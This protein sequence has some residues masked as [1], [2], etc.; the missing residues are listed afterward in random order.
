MA[1]II[2]TTFLSIHF[3]F[4][5]TL[6]ENKNFESLANRMAN[7][8][9]A[10]IVKAETVKKEILKTMSKEKVLIFDARESREFEVSHLPGAKHVGYN[11][12]NAKKATEGIHKDQKIIVYCTVGYRSGQVAQKLRKLGYN[13]HNLLGGITS[14]VNE[15]GPLVNFRNT[16]TQKVHT[17]SKKRAKWFERGELIH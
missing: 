7:K 3:L 9:S 13:A 14:W 1:N 16:P 2:L 4:A 10:P 8:S 17:Y 11:K 15:D 12:F 6:F 5:F